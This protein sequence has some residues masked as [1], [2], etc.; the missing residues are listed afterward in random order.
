MIERTKF[1]LPTPEG[2]A[3]HAMTEV[4]AAHLAGEIG[5]AEAINRVILPHEEAAKAQ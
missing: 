3:L 2:R 5:P 1:D 4:I